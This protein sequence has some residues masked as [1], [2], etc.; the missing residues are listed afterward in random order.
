MERIIARLRVKDVD[1]PN[2][3]WMITDELERGYFLVNP[4]GFKH[5][6]ITPE[7]ESGEITVAEQL[8]DGE[9]RFHKVTIESGKKVFYYAKVI[10]EYVT[11]FFVFTFNMSKDDEV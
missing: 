10:N 8:E 5:V 4:I 7:S 2:E 3:N 11:K 6:V 9:A 1:D